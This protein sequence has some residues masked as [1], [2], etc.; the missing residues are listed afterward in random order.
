MFQIVGA[1]GVAW[2]VLW[3]LSIR[4]SD[5]SPASSASLPVGKSL[6]TSQPVSFLQIAMSRQFVMCLIVVVTINVCW[7]Q[8]RVWMPKF[9]EVGRGFSKTTT[10]DINTWFNVMTDIGCISAG[11]TTAALHRGGVSVFS[12]R[13]RVFTVCSLLVSVGALIPWLPAGPG[14][15]AVL[16]TV[17]LGALGLFPCFYAFSQELSVTHQGKVT[18]LL[19]TCAWIVPSVWHWQFGRWVDQTKSYD[20]GMFIASL[21]PL[22]AVAAL[23]A[24]GPSQRPPTPV[25]PHSEPA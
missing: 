3:L 15:I 8:F 23:W 6:P 10:L 13:Y 4:T 24:L 17:G 1:L 2:A 22:V 9:L 25:A 12:A 11:L 16:M 7:H 14:L 18:G 20:L 19:G 5:L 21:L